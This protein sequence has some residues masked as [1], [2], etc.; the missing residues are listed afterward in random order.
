[1][2]QQEH[3]SEKRPTSKTSKLLVV[4]YFISNIKSRWV[5]VVG[6]FCDFP[7]GKDMIIDC[8]SLPKNR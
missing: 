6:G 7:S 1:M 8:F 2:S 3:K 4:F 5:F